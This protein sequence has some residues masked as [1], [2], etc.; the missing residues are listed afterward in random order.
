MKRRIQIHLRSSFAALTLGL[1]SAAALP[2]FAF[3]AQETDKQEPHFPPMEEILQGAGGGQQSP[4]DRMRELFVKVE[5]N[6]QEIDELLSDAAA[7]DTS[8]LSEVE[9]ANI[10]DLLNN[11]LERGREA[12]ESILEI[13]EIA[14]QQGAASSQSSSGKGDPS[15]DPSSSGSEGSPLNRGQQSQSSE[16]TPEMQGQKPGSQNQE[17]E[18]PGGEK[19]QDKPGG[20]E[21]AEGQDGQDPKRG[22]KS[23]GEGENRAGSEKGDAATDAAANAARAGEGW[24][25][26]PSH[27]QETF[28]SAGRSELPVRYREWIDDYY[29]KLNR[30]GDR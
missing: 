26:L 11:T 3:P 10:A 2:S 18:Q 1:V 20:Q 16:Q 30:R 13:I 17:G 25:D 5:V 7:G 28:S 12:Q 24:G 14:K 15:G 27:V 22:D 23:D 9:N 8:R 29:R 21:P 19:P 4:E 6:L